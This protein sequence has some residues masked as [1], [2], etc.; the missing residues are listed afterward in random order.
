M[1]LCGKPSQCWA[2]GS[3]LQCQSLFPFLNLCDGDCGKA[4]TVAASNLKHISERVQ[5][6]IYPNR[7]IRLQIHLGI[8]YI[9]TVH[10]AYA[11]CLSSL[12][13]RSL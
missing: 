4:H 13:A 7:N 12:Y 10:N 11:K 8:F 3:D 6:C 9:G 5:S 2:Y 1:R